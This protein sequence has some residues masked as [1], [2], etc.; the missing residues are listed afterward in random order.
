MKVIDAQV[1]RFRPA[2]GEVEAAL[3][4]RTRAELALE[5][6]IAAMDAVGIA[7][8][9]VVGARDFCTV[10]VESYG[11]RYAGVVQLE[12][13]DRPDV[14]EVVEELRSTPGIVGLRLK[15]AS[16]FG[17]GNMPLLRDGAY[18]PCF[19]AAAERGLPVCA[20]LSGQLDEAAKIAQRHPDLILVLDHLGLMPPP[21]VPVTGD[22]LDPL[23]D[24]LELGRY[25][26][27]VVKLTAAPALSMSG[28][29]YRDVWPAVERLIDAFGPERLLWGSDVTRVRGALSGE[30]VA[31]LEHS[32]GEL[33]SYIKCSEELEESTKSL[34]LGGAL[35]RWFRWTPSPQPPGEPAPDL[36]K[37]GE[38]LK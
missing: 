9:V 8:A 21:A 38:V 24:V 10:A 37:T 12:D 6:G 2:R 32:Y 5:I 1:H 34:L 3:P 11:D 23:P 26:N 15:L 18:E 17:A 25:P 4:D 13:G 36:R 30:T 29:P 20:F 19:R 16:P 31:G 22:L 27:V 33:L 35:E 14:G 28:Y 7:G